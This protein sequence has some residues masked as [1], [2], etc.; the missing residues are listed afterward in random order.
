MVP[1]INVLSIH[2][3]FK[4]LSVLD[5]S[6]LN[7]RFSHKLHLGKISAKASDTDVH[8][9]YILYCIKTK[10]LQLLVIMTFIETAPQKD[11]GVAKNKFYA[12]IQLSV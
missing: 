6:H 9:L 12:I 2:Y 1:I 11:G 8:T 5:I 10:T 3:D 7:V 4:T